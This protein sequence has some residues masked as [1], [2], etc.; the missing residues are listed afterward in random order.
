MMILLLLIIILY[1]C[2][3]FS[4]NSFTTNTVSNTLGRIS[5]IRNDRKSL[6]VCYNNDKRTILPILN[7]LN[8]NRHIILASGSPRRKELMNLIGLNQFNVITSNFDETLD[9]SMFKDAPAYCLATAQCKALDVIKNLEM[10]TLCKKGTILISSDTIVEIDGMILE[11]PCD[12]DDALRMLTLL[13]GRI[14]QV[15]TSICI[16]SNMNNQSKLLEVDS[17]VSTSSI[18]FSNFSDDDLFSYV[19]TKEPYDKA[20]SYGIQGL[21]AMF[22]ESIKGDYFTIMGFP[23]FLL[24]SSLASLYHN[25]KL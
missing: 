11:K 25:K 10:K 12:K 4:L 14:H 13:R 1:Y 17:F 7:E 24:S 15:H 21:G 5:R 6:T 3:A 8:N 16:Y 2:N 18:T 23:V 20:G 22:V 19:S 9:K